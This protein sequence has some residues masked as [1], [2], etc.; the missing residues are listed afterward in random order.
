L[1]SGIIIRKK[2]YFLRISPSMKSHDA[3]RFGR[4]HI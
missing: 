1:Q 3:T 4:Y 2:A